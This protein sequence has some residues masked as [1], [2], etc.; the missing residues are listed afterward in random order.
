MKNIEIKDKNIYNLIN[1]L[2]VNK[3]DVLLITSDVVQILLKYKNEEIDFNKLIDSFIE[4]IGNSGTVLFPT[5][6]WNFCKGLGF[7]YY[8]TI[9]ETGSLPK[10]A[11]KRKDFLRTRHPIYSFAVSGKDKE[12]LYNIDCESGWSSESI[13]NYLYENEAKNLFIGMDYKNGFTF[14]H[15]IEEKNKVK[16]RFFKTFTGE[17]INKENKKSIKNYKMFV[18]NLKLN[19]ATEINPRLDEVMLEAKCY[20]KYRFN[21]IDISLINLKIAGDIID[22]DI[23]NNGNLIFSRSLI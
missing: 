16:Y 12:K 14:D 2:D 13:F 3:N 19:G 6:S 18:R 22:K 15:F 4:K 1:H 5:Y 21:E 17:Y 7:D 8:K 23:K 9:P 11:L 20:K 10:I